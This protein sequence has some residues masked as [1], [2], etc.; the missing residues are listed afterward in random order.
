MLEGEGSVQS[1]GSGSEDGVKPSSGSD[2]SSTGSGLATGGGAASLASGDGGSAPAISGDA[3]LGAEAQGQPPS[4]AAVSEFLFG[5]RKWQSQKQAEDAYRSM[6]GRVPET[7][8]KA[9]ELEKAI[10]ERDAELQALRSVV[11]RPPQA[12]QQGQGAVRGQTPDASAPF[13]ERLAQSGNLDFLASLLETKEGEDPTIGVKRFTLGMAQ[14]MSQ[15]VQ[16]QVENLRNQE[17][18]PI[19]QRQQFSQHMGTAMGAVRSLASEFSELDES[20]QSPEAQEHQQAFV[21]NLK[22]FPPE[23]VREN[24]QFAMLATALVTRYQHGTP[25]FSQAPGTSGSP[26]ARAVM[27][28]E[29]ALGAAAGSPISGTSTPRPRPPGAA[30]ETAEDRI[31][32]ENAEVPGRFRSQGGIDLGFGPA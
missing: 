7:Q 26:S 21:E 25:V 13:A 31:R 10:A 22:Q 16:Q 3:A 2:T 9:A 8:R 30:P 27:A 28:S 6:M 11:S 1:G 20:N 12:A 14:I 29:Q 18:A 17:I 15:E 5:G 4:A 23:F 19:L 24:P 32:R